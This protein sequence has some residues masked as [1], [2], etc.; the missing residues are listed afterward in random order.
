M[1]EALVILGLVANIFQ[2]IEQGCVILSTIKEVYEAGQT[3][4][5]RHIQ[6]LLEDVKNLSDQIKRFGPGS[7]SKDELAIC[8]YSADCDNIA[9]KLNSIV[10][11]LSARDHARSKT[12]EGMRVA[13]HTVT[14]K[15]E[16][17]KLVQTLNDLDY[18]LRT[19][20]ENVLKRK[21]AEAEEHQLSSIVKMI[22]RLDRAGQTLGIDMAK[23]LD[24]LRTTIMSELRSTN[25]GISNIERLANDS[26]KTDAYQSLLRSLVFP[27]IKQRYSDIELAH[28]KTLRWLFDSRKTSFSE[29]LGTG[30][31]IYWVRGLAGSGKST[32]MRHIYEQKRTHDILTEWAGSNVRLITAHFYFW[33][34][35]SKMQKSYQG[36]LQSLLF[37]IL[38]TDIKFALALCPREH[39]LDPWTVEELLD[40]FDRIP[41][42]VTSTT[43][44]CFFVDGLDEY[45][46]N[47]EDII[48]MVKKLSSCPSIKICTSSRPWNRFRVA[49]ESYSGLILEDLTMSDIVE[50][51]KAELEQNEYFQKSV[52][53]DPRCKDIIYQVASKAHGVFLWV[54]LVVRSLKRDV[55]AQETFE[56]LQIRVD[57]LPPT[58]EA[59]FQKIFERIDPAYRRETARL[60]LL[61]LHFQRQEQ[62]PLP[63][64]VPLCLEL[65][66]HN[67]DY[68]FKEPL[69]SVHNSNK[70]YDWSTRL[71]D[72]QRRAITRLNDRCRDLLQHR[73][74]SAYATNCVHSV[75]IKFLHRTVRDFLMNNYTDQLQENAGEYSPCLSFAKILL[76]LFKRYPIELF[77]RSHLL[78]SNGRRHLVPTSNESL[79]VTLSQFWSFV[80]AN[81]GEIDDKV[82]DDFANTTSALYM[83]DWVTLLVDGP[84]SKKKSFPG[85]LRMLTWAVY[86]SLTDYVQ[87]NWKPNT[88]R[89]LSEYEI[90]PLSLALEPK[91][92]NPI[93]E[94]RGTAPSCKMLPLRLDLDMVQSLLELRCDPNELDAGLKFLSLYHKSC[95]ADTFSM[96]DTKN[97]G[98]PTQDTIALIYLAR[99]YYSSSDT[100][101]QVTKILLEYGLYFPP[102][103]A[104]ISRSRFE[105]L[106]RP[107]FGQRIDELNHIHDSHYPQVGWPRVIWKFFGF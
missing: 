58:L 23:D 46:G 52:Q 7:L 53:E 26:R 88:A 37:Q 41:N 60:F 86:V 9:S 25:I 39:T 5:V 66:N 107:V 75:H 106:F 8:E 65:E 91:S 89:L 11:K 70:V 10:E 78:K 33:N 40:V 93:S 57:E 22:D 54:F 24:L 103:G 100:V 45:D 6:L 96:H 99:D 61:A 4:Q 79:K 101:F 76:F 1:A 17:Q 48:A 30:K 62:E 56:N 98:D 67:S 63:V 43:K 87:R 47:E 42:L 49:F 84:L 16:I 102:W 97:S 14:K 32:L 71:A 29:W 105:T 104:N 12:L 55:W 44:F 20:L 74:D 59:F 38:K 31:G 73:V 27:D 85:D 80:Q 81:R 50:Y 95:F 18:R 21:G 77:F 34:Q 15:N 13:Y 19:R 64:L 28:K 69:N 72:D 82:L 51:I 2:F 94:L 35:G 83:V 68:A 90:T 36:F 92:L 3:I